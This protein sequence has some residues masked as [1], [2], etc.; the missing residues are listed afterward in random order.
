MGS[1][2]MPPKKPPA[3]V[4]LPGWPTVPFPTGPNR[5]ELP[6]KSGV[7]PGT[8]K[9]SVAL[10]NMAGF[11]AWRGRPV[12]V[13]VIFIGNNSWSV[14]Y[15]A[16]LTNEVLQPNGAVAAM[17]NNGIYPVMTVPLVTK[18]DAGKFSM[19]ATG[20]I[21][22]QHTAIAKK[23]ASVT[24]G[25]P[26]YLRLGHEADEGYPWSYTGNDG[27][28][29]PADPATYRA[30]WGR[31]ATIYHNNV[32]GAI[33]VWNVLKNTRLRPVDYYPGDGVVDVLS[34][35]IYDNGSGGYCDSPTGAAWTKMCYGAF[36]AAAG[37]S[38]G[39]NG[40]LQFAKSHGKK[41]A[42][43]EWGATND[44]LAAGNGAN[45]SWFVTGMFNFFAANYQD[46]EYESYYNRA[47]GGRHQIWPKTSYN[48]LPSDA[49]LNAYR[50]H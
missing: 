33:M 35:D 26:I 36:N 20:G 31:I 34:I 16:Y 5:S 22:A 41:V 9:G 40:W 13:G 37:T 38:K 18:A 12:D 49:Y 43:D 45:N 11:G 14:S 47:G 44:D 42:F 8:G 15:E 19:V 2:H 21:D 23:I 46:I 1:V 48:P 29:D 17:L 24:Q 10:S 32:P 25:R 30:A 4:T 6:W 28:E 7:S 3:M 50:P 27:A 39:A